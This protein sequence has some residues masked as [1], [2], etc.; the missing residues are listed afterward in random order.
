MHALATTIHIPIKNKRKQSVDIGKDSPEPVKQFHYEIKT[1]PHA[2]QSRQGKGK[3]MTTKIIE[4]RKAYNSMAVII[5][6]PC[7]NRRVFG[8][9]WQV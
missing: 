2:R 7:A 6:L 1:Q 5:M 9:S 3:A 4:E 8:P